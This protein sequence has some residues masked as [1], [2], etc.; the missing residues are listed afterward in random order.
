MGTAK[1]LNAQYLYAEEATYGVVNPSPTVK[2]LK[3]AVAGESLG[4]TGEEVRS[5]SLAGSGLLEAVRLGNRDVGGSIPIEFALAGIGTLLKHA[6]G[7]NTTSGTGP[8]THAM[9]RGALPV[10]LTVEKQFKDVARN[11][12]FFGGRVNR[13][14]MSIGTSG[15]VTGSIDLIAKSVEEPDPAFTDPAAS[16]HTP[17]AHGDC[18]T[19]VDGSATC[20]RGFSFELNNG[21]ERQRCIG[22]EW[23]DAADEGEK[24]CSGTIAFKKTDTSDFFDDWRNETERAIKVVMTQGAHSLTVEFPRARFFGQPVPLIGDLSTVEY[25]MAFTALRDV[26]S[27]SDIKVTLI[28]AESAV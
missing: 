16:V 1:G 21:L 2:R 17:I 26:T 24:S 13:L 10:G 23:I 6:L 8:Y 12:R 14:A 3:A 5:G 11:Y 4:V 28:N 22:D 27:G 18:T 9:K 19:F 25:Q 20:F 7:G 15:L